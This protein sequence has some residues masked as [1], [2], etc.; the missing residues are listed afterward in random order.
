MLLDSRHKSR[1]CSCTLSDSCVCSAMLLVPDTGHCSAMLL[2]HTRRQLRLLPTIRV[3]GL[4]LV[5]TLALQTYYS[6][7]T[8]L[9]STQ[10]VPK[11]FTYIVANVMHHFFF[12]STAPLPV[13]PQCCHRARVHARRKAPPTPRSAGARSAVV[14]QCRPRARVRARQRTPPTPRSAGA[15][16]AGREHRLDL[17][18]HLRAMLRVRHRPGIHAGDVGTR[19]PVYV[20]IL[21]LRVSWRGRAKYCS[22]S[23]ASSPPLSGESSRSTDFSVFA[24]MPRTCWDAS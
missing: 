5:K 11:Q 20:S 14:P 3:V 23:F 16:S 4:R 18:E 17:R 10:L 2:V 21:A 7:S 12:P 13:A 9:H 22:L 6:G 8:V 19:L 1:P 15:S 24:G